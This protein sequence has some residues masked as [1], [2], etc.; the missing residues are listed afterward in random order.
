MSLVD[1]IAELIGRCPD[2]RPSVDRLSE[3]PVALAQILLL[4][5]VVLADGI[6]E[7]KELAVFERICAASFDIDPADMPALHQLLESPA[8]RAAEAD[9]VPLVVTLDS[10]ER[11][12][13][14]GRMKRLA[15][16]SSELKD[17][18]ERLVER[19]AL[20]LGIEPPSSKEQELG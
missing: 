10:T 15:E 18:A 3:D 2:A 20:M 14:L 19:T 1:S 12:V 17:V 8:G 4:F 5:R 6:V 11:T 7:A 13:L 9:M 16:A